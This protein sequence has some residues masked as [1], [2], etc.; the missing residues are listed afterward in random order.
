MKSKAYVVISACSVLLFCALCLVILYKILTGSINDMVFWL[1]I[2]LFS[3]YV[4][5]LAWVDLQV[6]TRKCKIT[7]D[8]IR[9]KY[10]LSTEKLF[11]WEQ[12]QQICLCFK[13]LEKR[14]IPPHF[15]DQEIICFILKTAKKNS[16]GFWNVYSKRYFR[17]ILFVRCSEE[18]MK[19]LQ[20]NCP[21]DILDLRKDKIYQNK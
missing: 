18:V 12:L 14:Y 20:E 15:T 7:Q 11:A 6:E 10:P 16:W 5:A 4:F 8:G 2:L 17:K 19:E 9:V 13:P 21:T 1:S 3:S